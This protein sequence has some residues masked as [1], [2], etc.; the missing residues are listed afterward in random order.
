MYTRLKDIPVYELK[1]GTISA[2]FY[3][4]VQ[5]AL[6]KLGEEIQLDLPKL[7]H[8]ELIL[9]KEA[10]IIIDTQLNGY[11][12]AAWTD[13]DTVHRD[14]LHKPIPC[15]IKH[16]HMH[17]NLILDRSLEA[18]ELL[19]GEELMDHLADTSSIIPFKK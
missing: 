6:N 11:P 17:A 10:W 14:N 1:H 18:M 15:Q 5:F 13:F 12:I 16:Y 9:Q 7:R 2:H 8:L 19:L 4:H 3:N